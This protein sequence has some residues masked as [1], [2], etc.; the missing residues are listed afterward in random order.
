MSPLAIALV[1]FPPMLVLLVVIHELGHYFAARIFKVKVSE[2]GIGYPPRA[3]AIYAGRTAVTITDNTRVLD[4]EAEGEVRPGQVVRLISV[5]DRHGKL[6][7]R[8]VER[9]KRNSLLTS[10]ARRRRLRN[11]PALEMPEGGS[12]IQQGRI[13]TLD[14]GAMVV[15][16]TAYSI[17]W[18]PLGG[19]VRVAGE[20]D[21]AVPQGLARRPAWQR[22]VVLA[23]GSAMNALF[24]LVAFTL[25]FM[26]PYTQPVSVVAEI[27]LVQPG[28]PAELAG[29][30]PKD[31]VIS[32]DGKKLRGSNDLPSAINRAHGSDMIWLIDRSGYRF[33][34]LVK[35]IHP[36]LPGQGGAGVHYRLVPYESE[37]RKTRPPWTAARMGAASVW[38]TLEIM[39][40]E[41]LGAFRGSQ[42]QLTGPI[43][44]AQQTGHITAQSGLYGWMVVAIIL[45]LNLAIINILPIPMLDGGRLLFV[46]IEC[47]RG[48]RRVPPHKEHLVHMIGFMA[49]L[50]LFIA[51][52]AKDLAQV[53][54]I[55]TGP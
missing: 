37:E 17:N 7:A 54:R 44:I 53:V 34:A 18:L 21:P 10:I 55:A 36:P 2:I 23:A 47:L 6:E 20:S 29:I 13:R 48:G 42:G 11:R 46:V 27:E 32:V 39:G 24:P 14:D 8:Y 22:I 26:L 19:F 51:V 40:E 5:E 35:P 28:S 49:L 33:S 25:I 50:A 52:S 31:R 30:M 1:T 16:D 15:A 38:K 4:L 41:T 45:S 9:I 3:F 12:L 43:G